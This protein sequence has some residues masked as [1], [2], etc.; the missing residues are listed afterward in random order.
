MNFYRLRRRIYIWISIWIWYAIFSSAPIWSWGMQVWY[1]KHQNASGSIRKIQMY[2]PIWSWGMHVW[3]H[4][5]LRHAG[6]KQEASGACWNIPEHTNVWIH[7][8]LSHTWSIRNIHYLIGCWTLSIVWNSDM[9][10]SLPC[11]INDCLVDSSILDLVL[12]LIDSFI[13][14]YLVNSF[15]INVNS[16]FD[17]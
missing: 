15:I 2:V 7:L 9:A 4:P 8:K 13:S 11:L 5:K 14:E 6:M 17:T 16:S 3:F 12:V 10:W 1:R